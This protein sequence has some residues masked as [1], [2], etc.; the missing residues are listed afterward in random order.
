MHTSAARVMPTCSTL[1][2]PMKHPGPTHRSSVGSFAI[3]VSVAIFGLPLVLRIQ[4][5]QPDQLLR[6]AL[7]LSCCRLGQL[8]CWSEATQD[9]LKVRQAHGLDAVR[10]A[11]RTVRRQGIVHGYRH[12]LRAHLHEVAAAEASAATRDGP[13]RRSDKPL[14][15]LLRS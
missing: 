2:G 3:A 1:S 10:C 7:P 5:Q 12:R 14:V 4:Q 9:R 11:A 8:R 13:K 6:I 15:W